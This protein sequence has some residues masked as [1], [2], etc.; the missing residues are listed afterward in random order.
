MFLELRVA[1]QMCH[2]EHFLWSELQVGNLEELTAGWL[3]QVGSSA[4]NISE[5]STL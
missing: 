1:R 3:V 5:S 2:Q 4:V